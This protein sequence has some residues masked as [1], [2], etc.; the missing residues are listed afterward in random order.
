MFVSVPE[1]TDQRP[2]APAKQRILETADVLFTREGIRAVGVDWLIEE[3]HVTKA[4]FY[5]HFRAKD[6]LVLDYLAD[7][8]RRIALDVALRLS[9]ISSPADALFA[10]RDWTA[11]DVGNPALRGC[12]F[13]SAAVEYPLDD[14]PVRVS[15]GVH[16]EWL[17]DLFENLLAQLGHLAPHEGADDLM[18][19]R[20]GALLGGYAGSP[21]SAR[22]SLNRVFES[23]VAAAVMSHDIVDGR[24]PIFGVRPFFILWLGSPCSG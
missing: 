18:L 2:L 12:A 24:T 1:N 23:V 7:R 4:T 5:K 17:H 20:D 21:D 14:H 15:V 22:G 6:R 11:A 9:S 3:S 8:H 10:L 19:A 13:L 16:R